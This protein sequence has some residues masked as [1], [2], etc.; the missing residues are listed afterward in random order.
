MPPSKNSLVRQTTRFDRETRMPSP[1]TRRLQPY[2]QL[3]NLF[4]VPVV[5]Y[6]LAFAGLA[7]L[8]FQ[9]IEATEDG[10][11]TEEDAVTVSLPPSIR[12]YVEEALGYLPHISLIVTDLRSKGTKDQREV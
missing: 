8:A 12:P 1:S 9:S 3:D 2:I 6:R 10:L 5:P 11:I 4:V 7:Q